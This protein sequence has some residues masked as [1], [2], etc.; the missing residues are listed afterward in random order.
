MPERGVIL[1]G[2]GVEWRGMFADPRKTFLPHTELEPFEN[3]F[4][5]SLALAEDAAVFPPADPR[6][7]RRIGRASYCVAPIPR[8]LD[9]NV[10]TLAKSIA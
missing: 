4:A 5:P 7:L 3:R 2:R 6:T 1:Q 9:V 10:S 8:E